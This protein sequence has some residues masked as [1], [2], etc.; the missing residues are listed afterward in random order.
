MSLKRTLSRSKAAKETDQSADDQE[1]DP[2]K[3]LENECDQDM[4]KEVAPATSLGLRNNNKKVS[5]PYFFLN[6]SKNKSYDKFNISG[7]PSF[8]QKNSFLGK[9]PSMSSNK[10]S[11]QGV[12]N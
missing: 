8:Q 3:Q 2:L 7:Y 10:S 4:F 11:F 9:F 1:F 6:Q 5:T 12:G